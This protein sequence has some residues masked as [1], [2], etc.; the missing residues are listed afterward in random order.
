MIGTEAFSLAP[1]WHPNAWDIRK[2]ITAGTAKVHLD[3]QFTRYRADNSTSV[4][5]ECRH[6]A[7]ARQR[8]SSIP[9]AG[10]GAGRSQLYMHCTSFVGGSA[11]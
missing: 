6:E 4:T 5:S 8:N 2:V 7:P 9:I 3:V 10:F 1:E 11:G